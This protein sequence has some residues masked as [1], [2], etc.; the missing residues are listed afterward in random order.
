MTQNLQVQQEKFNFQ[1][2]VTRVR[3]WGEGEG[4]LRMF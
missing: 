1:G 2:K 4:A 3:E